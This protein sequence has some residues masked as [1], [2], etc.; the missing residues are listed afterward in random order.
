ML[1][2]FEAALMLLFPLVIGVAIDGLLQQV[3]FGLYLLGLLGGLSVITGAARRLYDTRLYAVMYAKAA[4]QIVVQQ[5]NCKSNVS[6]TTAR[7]NMAKELVEFME[8]SFPATIDCLIGLAGTLVVVWLLQI[9]VF[10]AC[11]IATCFI[12]FIYAWT[13]PRTLALNEGANDESERSVQVIADQAIPAVRLHFRRIMQWNVRLSDLETANFSISW[14]T[15]IAL[16][17]FSVVVTIQNGVTSQGQVLSILMYVF[18]YIE[19]VVALPLFYQQFL[20]LQEIANR[21]Q[22]K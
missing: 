3:Y 14:L 16:L 5:R 7:T 11:L 20:R 17:L 9:H 12:I 8:N 13:S 22:P 6:V 21:L 2:G 15:M 10:V 1:V 19:S 18:G 4:E